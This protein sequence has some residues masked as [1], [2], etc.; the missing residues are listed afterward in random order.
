MRQNKPQPFPRSNWSISPLI[1]VLGEINPSANKA[2]TNRNE[3][4]P[5]TKAQ[6]F[7]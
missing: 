7:N 2:P 4:T 6:P 3:L 5:P 1:T